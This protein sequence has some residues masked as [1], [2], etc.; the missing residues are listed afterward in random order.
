M[1]EV[2]NRTPFSAQGY[3]VR[4][5]KGFEHWCVA[6]RASFGIRRDG[7]V[8]ISDMQQ[9]V[10]LAPVY[11]DDGAEELIAE[12]D[13]SPFRPFADV[14]VSGAATAVGGQPFHTQQVDIAVG[15]MNKSIVAISPRRIERHAGQWHIVDR[16]AVAACKAPA[17]TR[18]N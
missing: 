3:F 8:S 2:V 16:P 5:R 17:S 15:V 10:R 4:D 12:S 9:P 13:F 7:L 1:W 6:L 18:S 14:L 11:A